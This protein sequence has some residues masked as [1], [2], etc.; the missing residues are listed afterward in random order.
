[1]SIDGIRIGATL[2]AVDP[3][4]EFID[5]M[6]RVDDWGYD[7]FWIADSSLHARYVYVYMTLAVTHTDR[8]RLGTNCTH[9]I[10]LHPAMTANAFTTINELSGGR[11]I[12]GIG[13]GGGP[14]SELGRSRPASINEVEAV[15]EVCRRLMDGEEVDYE[16]PKFELT[17]GHL[18]FGTDVHEPPKIYLT[19]TGPRMLELAGRT[20]DGVLVHCG[21]SREGLEFALECIDKGASAAG[22]SIDEIDVAWQLWGT[23]DED[24]ASAKVA[25]RPGVAS[26]ARI[27]PQYC[28]LAGIPEQLVQNVS[29]AYHGQHFTE[30]YRAHALVTDDMVDKL[31]VAGAADQWIERLEV[32][33]S[34]G[35]DHVELFPIGDR[36]RLIEGF[37]RAVSATYR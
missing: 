19:A 24:I 11:A 27:A 5:T 36:M 26:L 35:V 20:A 10:S 4:D 32:G 25:A 29:D 16:G 8:V 1:M 30:A 12:L 15:I 34:L 2:M 33:R 21:A 6:K 7:F 13:A 28:T 23:W 31:T 22:R 14:T 17:R 37:A 9:P 18:H 3:P